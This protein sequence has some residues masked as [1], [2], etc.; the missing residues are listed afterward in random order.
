M[1][2]KR[3]MKSLNMEYKCTIWMKIDD[4]IN[5]GRKQTAKKVFRT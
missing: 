1:K 3:Q 5:N 4:Y 2:D